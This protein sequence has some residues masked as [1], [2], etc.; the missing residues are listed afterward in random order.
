MSDET[1]SRGTALLLAVGRPPS[2]VP[3]VD[4]VMRWRQLPRKLAHGRL[5][6]LRRGRHAALACRI[7]GGKSSAWKTYALTR[8]GC[9][10]LLE[11]L[12]PAP[13]TDS[14]RLLDELFEEP[15]ALFTPAPG[16]VE[17]AEDTEE[18]GVEEGGVETAEERVARLPT[19][20][21]LFPE[22]ALHADMRRCDELQEDVARLELRVQQTRDAFDAASDARERARDELGEVL[23]EQ[24]RRIVAVLQGFEARG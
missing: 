19:P 17:T 2:T 11:L 15:V 24:L 1:L 6:N 7:L 21:V 8:E 3:A 22:S 10:Q 18:G 9:R 5:C 13:G 23:R 4:L 12:P 20:V 16:G 14:V